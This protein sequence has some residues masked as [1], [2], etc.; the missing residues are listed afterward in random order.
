MRSVTFSPDGKQLASGGRDGSVRLWA[1]QADGSAR[2]T[3]SLS[4]N[5]GSVRSVAFSPDGKQ[6]ACAGRD[7]LVRLWALQADGS[8]REAA[9][10]SGHQDGA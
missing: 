4:G 2:E 8:A 1:L 9:S 7:G 3:A 5:R 6:L 10:L